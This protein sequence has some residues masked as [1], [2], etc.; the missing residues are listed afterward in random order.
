MYSL[1][2]V[3]TTKSNRLGWCCKRQKSVLSLFRRLDVEDQV[4]TGLVS[5]GASMLGR[6]MASSWPHTVSWSP[7]L[8][9]AGFSS[10][11]YVRMQPYWTRAHQ[12][13]LIFILIISVKAVSVNTVVFLRLLG[14][15]IQ[16]AVFRGS[17]LV[18]TQSSGLC[19]SPG[20]PRPS[21]EGCGQ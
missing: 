3:A 19:T 7:L 21:G 11:F 12:Q 10:P 8:S 5:P 17:Q 16:H 20:T 9:V 6:Q 15:R 1:I 2:W 18:L 4:L 13:D 14:V